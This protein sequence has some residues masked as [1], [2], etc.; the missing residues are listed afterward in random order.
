MDAVFFVLQ[1]QHLFGNLFSA[2]DI[3]KLSH[4]QSDKWYK[5]LEGYVG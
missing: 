4:V 5:V 2:G 3:Q 1:D